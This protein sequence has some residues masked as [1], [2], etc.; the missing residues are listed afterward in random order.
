AELDDAQHATRRQT[1][2]Q[3]ARRGRRG[4]DQRERA[5]QIAGERHVLRRA[6]AQ[7]D[8]AAVCLA[9]AGAPRDDLAELQAVLELAFHRTAG[10]ED[11][12]RGRLG[13]F[14]EGQ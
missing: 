5:L 11:A 4:R 2:D 8:E 1:A 6:A 13:Q 14:Y 3:I 9:A 7:E 12:Q 10:V